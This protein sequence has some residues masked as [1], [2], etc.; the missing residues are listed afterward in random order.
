MAFRYLLYSMYSSPSWVCWIDRVDI[1]F[2][3]L[4]ICWKVFPPH[5]Y[6]AVVI[7]LWGAIARLQAAIQSWA[8]MMVCC[9]FLGAVE[10]GFGTVSPSFFHFSFPAPA[11]RDLCRSCCRCKCVR[12]CIGLRIER[13]LN[14]DFPT[15]IVIYF[16]GGANL[17][18][19][20]C[21]VVFPAGRTW[22]G[23]VS[24]TGGA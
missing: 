17:F 2:E 14:R 23:Q 13:Y 18:Y 5:T 11:H 9:F 10:C 7:F 19:G 8:G 20:C 3:W 22:G 16:R 21:G 15:E 6:A 4:T 12:G 1:L 24:K